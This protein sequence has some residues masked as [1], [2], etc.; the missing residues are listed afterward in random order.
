MPYAQGEAHEIALAG[1]AEWGSQDPD[2]RYMSDT[3]TLD[4]IGGRGKAERQL[5]GHGFTNSYTALSQRVRQAGLLS[6][7]PIF[8]AVLGAGLAVVLAGAA[9][10]FVLLGDSWFQLLIAAVL[11]VVFA[12]VAFL[13]HEAAHRQ[14]FAKG[15]SNDRLGR[16]IG[17]FVVGMSYAWWMGKHTR[18]HGN[19]NKVGKDPDIAGDVVIFHADRPKPLHGVRAWLA[20]RQGWLFFPLLTLEGINLHV[21]SFRFLM[22]KERVKGRWWELASLVVRFGIYFAVVFWALPFGMAC[23]F[24]GVQ[25]AIFGVYMGGTFAPNHKGMAIIPAGVKLDFF[26][27]QVLTSRNVAGRVWPTWL[28]GGLNYQI[29]HHLFPSMPRPHLAKARMIVREHCE[30][31]GVAYTEVSLARSYRAV[32]R[33]LNEVGLAARDPFE[34]PLAAQ[35]GR[36]VAPGGAAPFGGR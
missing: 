26:S 1:A 17:T 29:E 4:S 11:G 21:S 5:A 7:T 6:R 22:R 36:S 20:R 35:F 15:Q 23:A 24:L 30:E 16:I 13:S 10:G 25:F 3:G 31:I 19:P 14:I 34:C 28:M 9:A 8:Y 2:G 12:Q 32:V 33:Y 27:R 18:H